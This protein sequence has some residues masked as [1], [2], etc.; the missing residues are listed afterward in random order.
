MATNILTDKFCKTAPP[1][2]HYDRDG[3]D[4]NGFHLLVTQD[5]KRYWR[6][7]CRLGGK[8]KLMGFG[9]YPKVSLQLARERA[10]GAIATVG[11]GIDP[12]EKARCLREAAEQAKEEAKREAARRKEGAEREKQR[13]AIEAGNTFEQI[14]RRLH[15]D[16]VG[17]TTEEYRDK[18]LRQFEIHLFPAI[19]QKNIKDI[20]GRE[21]L[22]LFRGVAE[23]TNH[24]RKMTYMAKRLCQWTAEVYDLAHVEDTSFSVNPC[25]AIIKLLPRHGTQHMARI[26]FQEL[27]RFL[28]ALEQYGGYPVTKAAIWMLLYTGMRQAS[29]R[30][31]AWGDFDLDNAIWH[32]RP[33]KADKEAHDLPLPTQA[34]ALLR[35]IL[36][37][38]GQGADDLVFP[39]PRSNYSTMSEAAIGQAIERMGFQM[40]GHG[41]RGVVDT[42]LNELGY[43][44]RMVDVQIG[45]KIKD[46]VEAAYND[47]KH[48]EARQKMM[49]D[50]ADY[51]TRAAALNLVIPLRKQA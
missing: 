4:R 11:L 18:I 9:Q 5:G 47:A 25:R 48:F 23:K 37:M 20:E 49:Q 26:R 8:R 50:W 42:G 2:C 35:N 19:G 40:V 6:L 24:G 7:A 21:L 31:A 44:H 14:A 22:A 28:R 1:G 46:S 36:P 45:H 13:Q 15:A 43:N 34:V 17:K 12:V 41:L 33:E 16:K 10:A 30:R 29:V 38:T 32:R 39:S 51:L 3:K 27:P